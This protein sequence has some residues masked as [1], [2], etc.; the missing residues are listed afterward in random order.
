MPN[1]LGELRELSMTVMLP[2]YFLYIE[3]SVPCADLI[4]MVY[5]KDDLMMC[6][7]SK[8]I[9]YSTKEEG[10]WTVFS[11]EN[12]IDVTYV[13]SVD[14]YFIARCCRLASDDDEVVELS[15]D[16][17]RYRT[18]LK[19]EG[20]IKLAA[21]QY[22]L[23]VLM[24]MGSDLAVYDMKSTMDKPLRTK[25][26]IKDVVD[27]QFLSPYV[28]LM[29]SRDKLIS[30]DIHRHKVVW[31]VD[32]PKNH[33]GQSVGVGQ[34]IMAAARTQ[35]LEQSNTVMV[36]SQAGTLMAAIVFS[37]YLLYIPIVFF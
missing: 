10:D 19:A 13:E 11:L 5:V 1:D 27:L 21:S 17:T 37:R 9:R 26:S 22:F 36:L 32:M 25:D 3:K 6:T 16:M 31:S 4:K 34:F 29:L 23:A 20:I 12:M 33:A 24:D 30:Y 28:L 18:V 2:P 8:I 14:K 35:G 15:G 7:K